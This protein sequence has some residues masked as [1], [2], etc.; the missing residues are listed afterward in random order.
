MR[1]TLLFSLALAAGVSAQNV[2]PQRRF[3]ARDDPEIVKAAGACVEH[4][5]K[6]SESGIYKEIHLNRIMEAS[7]NEG[8]YH[9]N[10]FLKLE[11]KSSYF[12]SGQPTEAFNFMH[13]THLE[14]GVV[15]FAVDDF[16]AMDEE[17]IEEYWIKMVEEK[18][19]RRTEVLQ[20]FEAEFAEGA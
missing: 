3:R 1:R 10:I 5:Q 14:D 4:L 2:R 13:M 11:L 9:N 18:R 6:L 7:S 20:R 15:N 17:A 19:K 12:K 16:P 8:V